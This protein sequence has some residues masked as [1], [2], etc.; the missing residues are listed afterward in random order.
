MATFL[1]I[2]SLATGVATASSQYLLR[3][4]TREHCRRNYVRNTKTVRIRGR[5]VRQVWCIHHISKPAAPKEAPAGSLEWLLAR[6]S[7]AHTSEVLSR[8]VASFVAKNNN[9]K[10]P[11]PGE[12]RHWTLPGPKC[13]T[14]TENGAGFIHCEEEAELHVTYLEGRWRLVPCESE[15][16]YCQEAYTEEVAS[17]PQRY[18]MEL[19]VSGNDGSECGD[20]STFVFVGAEWQS[21]QSA[22]PRCNVAV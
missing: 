8:E 11:K 14:G 2:L 3:H 20:Y 13:K 10:E 18:L 1:V 5:R 7:V 15:S 12:Q 22:R 21:T 17:P 4:P 6:T 19:L 9:E 16:T